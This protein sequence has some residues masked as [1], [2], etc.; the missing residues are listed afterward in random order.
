MTA[1]PPLW[2]SIKHCRTLAYALGDVTGE[3]RATPVAVKAGRILNSQDDAKDGLLLTIMK[4]SRLLPLAIGTVQ[5][6]TEEKELFKIVASAGR[7]C[8]H[9]WLS[10]VLSAQ[11]RH[12]Q[13]VLAYHFQLH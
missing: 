5:R 8:L 4:L 1:A 10:C 12:F 13:A 6:L 7:S 11:H 3:K 9:L 2:M